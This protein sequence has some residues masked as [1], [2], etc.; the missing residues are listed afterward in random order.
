MSDESQQARTLDALHKQSVRCMEDHLVQEYL[1]H[2]PYA[3]D[4]VCRHVAPGSVDPVTRSQ[5][6]ARDLLDRVKPFHVWLA[7]RDRTEREVDLYHLVAAEL[8]KVA[9]HGWEGT[10]ICPV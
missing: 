4:L 1:V 5:M 2:R 10:R 3:R 6:E 9:E 7:A 8:M